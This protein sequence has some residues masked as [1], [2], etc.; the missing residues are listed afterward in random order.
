ML[1]DD[2]DPAVAEAARS[3]VV[4]PAQPSPNA[5]RKRMHKLGDHGQ[6]VH[7][8]RTLLQDLAT[9]AKNHTQPKLANAVPFDLITSPTR[10]QQ[11]ASISLASTIE[12][13]Q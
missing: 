3:S 2:A 7:S 4:G 9:I 10:L 13:S 6:P 1:L 8:L 5:R 11:C 12:C